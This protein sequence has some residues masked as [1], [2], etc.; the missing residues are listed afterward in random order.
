MAHC[1][2]ARIHERGHRDDEQHSHEA[3]D[4]PP[5]RRGQGCEHELA[6][7]RSSTTPRPGW[8][9]PHWTLPGRPGRRAAGITY[10]ADRSQPDDP[11]LARRPAGTCSHQSQSNRRA[12]FLPADYFAAIEG[13]WIARKSHQIFQF[14]ALAVRVP[15]VPWRPSCARRLSLA[16]LDEQPGWSRG[17]EPGGW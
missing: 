11:V 16:R 15:K 14:C 9:R 4:E 13:G 8:A 10:R 7:R 17:R 6:R 2:H 1:P 5:S 12:V 3:A